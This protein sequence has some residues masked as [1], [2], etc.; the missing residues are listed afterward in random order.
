[1]LAR[2]SRLG[3][4]YLVGLEALGLAVLHLVDE[5]LDRPMMLGTR[6]GQHPVPVG[7]EHPVDGQAYRL[8]QDVPQAVVDGRSVR[9]LSS[10]TS[11]RLP[12]RGERGKVED[13]LA[14]QRLL[15]VLQPPQ[16]TPVRMPVPSGQRVVPLDPTVGH[17]GGDL[18]V[19][20]AGPSRAPPPGAQDVDLDLLDREVSLVHGMDSGCLV[21]CP[22]RFSWR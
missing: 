18:T 22:D 5:L 2:F 12:A 6:V 10:A 3:R 1:M 7:S 8:A 11:L 20:C 16:V 13:A 19:P 9:A 15:G 21:G 14:D 17:D 4:V